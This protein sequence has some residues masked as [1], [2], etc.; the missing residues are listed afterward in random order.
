MPITR[1][2]QTAKAPHRDLGW[3][4]AGQCFQSSLPWVQGLREDSPTQDEAMTAFPD[5][6]HAAKQ[7][8]D[9]KGQIGDCDHSK[10][11]R[12]KGGGDHASGIPAV[13]FYHMPLSTL[14]CMASRVYG[15]VFE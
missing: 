11:P 7:D 12:A 4:P 3:R 5:A 15:V 1:L 10:P 9:K 6:G 8:R 13:L 14:I 2:E